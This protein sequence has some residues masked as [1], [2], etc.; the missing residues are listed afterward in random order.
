M[1]PIASATQAPT[2]ERGP[3]DVPQ[4]Q[5]RSVDSYPH[6]RELPSPRARVFEGD[7]GSS[8]VGSNMRVR[9]RE[10][11]QREDE[12]EGTDEVQRNVGS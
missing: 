11:G 1:T 4:A 6:R 9:P 7:M 10:Q 3:Y 5:L 12:A 2:I 8:D